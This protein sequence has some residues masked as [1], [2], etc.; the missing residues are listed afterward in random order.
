VR[1]WDTWN[2]EQSTHLVVLPD[3]RA[4]KVWTEVTNETN[5]LV[6]FCQHFIYPDG[7][8]LLSTATLRFLTLGQ[9]EAS[10]QSAGFSVEQ[11]YGGWSRQAPGSGDGEF[12]VVARHQLSG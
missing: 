2:K 6:S 10:L 11:V 5:Q 12:L 1:E 9:I 8:E 3:G 7:T 4:V